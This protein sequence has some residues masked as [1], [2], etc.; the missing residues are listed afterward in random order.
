[1]TASDSGAAASNNTNAP[2]RAVE[3]K[4]F[5]VVGKTVIVWGRADTIAE[6]AKEARAAMGSTVPIAIRRQ[7]SHEWTVFASDGDIEVFADY[8]VRVRVEPGA[9]LVR[10]DATL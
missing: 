8:T 10:F 4:S 6:A 7:R 1:M 2:K 5:V 9:E 3:K